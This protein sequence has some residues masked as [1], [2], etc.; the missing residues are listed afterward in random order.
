MRPFSSHASTV[1]G[2]A[3]ALTA[4]ISCGSP[5]PSAGPEASTVLVSAT[6]ERLLVLS[7]VE[8][9]I[10]GRAA[11]FSRQ[12]ALTATDLTDPELERLVPAVQREF[13][14]DLLRQDI[15]GSLVTQDSAGHMAEVVG[16][17][18]RG[19]SAE[20]RAIAEAYSPPAPLDSWLET[21]TT[22]PPDAD[23]IRT[24]GRWIEA[25][26]Q[27]PFFLLLEQA[28]DEAAHAVWKELRPSA[29]EFV[30]LRGDE[31]FNRLDRSFMAAAVSALHAHETVPSDL[32]ARSSA[33]YESTAGQWYV[34]AYQL[35]VARA[36]RAAGQRVVLRLNDD[37]VGSPD[38]S[39]APSDTQ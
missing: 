2:F 39:S 27:G 37:R 34:E 5:A 1:I 32:I 29:V 9:L 35:A 19:A 36:V 30:P 14:A 17:L 3:L 20:V 6:A 33:E 31:L 22:E 7:E 10:A 11:A 28:L 24:V 4:T 15:V 26:G 18:E 21:Y 25:R 8:S 23:R 38:Q 12:V 13:A 16:W